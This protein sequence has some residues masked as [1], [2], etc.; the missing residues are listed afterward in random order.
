VRYKKRYRLILIKQLQFVIVMLVGFGSFC[1]AE[2]NGGF[3]GSFLRIGLGA[4]GIAMGD[5]Q[6]ATAE[7]AF[8]SYYNAASSPYL[9]KSTFALSYSSMSLDRR[10]NYIGFA[11]PLKPFAGFSVGWIYSGVG[12][13][14]AYD[15]RGVDVGEINH[16]LH[17]IQFSF[18]IKIIPML[19]Q[20][21]K[22]KNVSPDLISVGILMKYVRE[23]LGD[24]ADFNYS[25]KGFGID[26][27]LMIKPVKELSLGY[28]IKDLNSKLESNTNDIFDRGTTLENKFPIT[29]RVG[30]FYHT[31][32]DWWALAYDFE[33]SDAGGK[34]HHLGTELIF[35]EAA[36]RLGYDD[37]HFTFGAGVQFRV[38]KKVGFIL[39]YAFI[40]D[41]EDEG[42][43][44]VF[45]WQFLF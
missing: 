19:Q 3:A 33:W 24:N 35:R 17:S 15:S 21:N 32:V 22:M 23:D 6:V 43:S 36:L 28:Q 12:D 5:A 31:P 16:G 7:N 40:G 44:H 45:S 18:G 25:G 30:V 2:G 42:A 14:R 9:K 11:S 4:R 20:S 13:I 37:D 8:G 38:Y 1:F 29:Q 41:V 34:K 27:G 10:F 26:L 39:D